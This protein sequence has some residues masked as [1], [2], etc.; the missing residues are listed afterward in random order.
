MSWRSDRVP[1]GLLGTAAGLADLAALLILGLL[2]FEDTV[3]EVGLAVRVGHGGGGGEA[4]VVA[5][6]F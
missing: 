2:E 1:L 3:G 6:G 4:G 5:L